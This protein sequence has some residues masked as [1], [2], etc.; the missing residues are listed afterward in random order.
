MALSELNE[1]VTILDLIYKLEKYTEDA[2]RNYKKSMEE[3]KNR[4]IGE[5]QRRKEVLFIE[6]KQALED[7]ANEK[8]EDLANGN[9]CEIIEKYILEKIFKRKNPK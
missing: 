4:I 8:N 6:Y 9:N 1:D 3:I 7:F 5:S 2:P